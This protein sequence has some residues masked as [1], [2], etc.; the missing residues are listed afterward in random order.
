M[1][2][3]QELIENHRG[4]NVYVRFEGFGPPKAVSTNGRVFI[5]KRK[6]QKILNIL[7][8]SQNG[9]E[10]VKQIDVTQCIKEYVNR[11]SQRYACLDSEDPAKMKFDKME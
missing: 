9:F 1:L 3:D 4:L 5:F 6:G 7:F 10:L 2:K 8:L 11:Y